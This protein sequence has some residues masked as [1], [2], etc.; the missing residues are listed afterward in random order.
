MARRQLCLASN[1]DVDDIAAGQVK[2]I[3]DGQR[4]SLPKWVQEYRAF[5]GTLVNWSKCDRLD[6]RRIS[7]IVRKLHEPLGRIFRHFIW[8]GVGVRINDESVAG[9]DPLFLHN[10]TPL[11]RR[12]AVRRAAHV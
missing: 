10:S 9:V 4:S 7:T 11:K 3:P 1:L 2:E 6:N 12:G 5:S 8:Q